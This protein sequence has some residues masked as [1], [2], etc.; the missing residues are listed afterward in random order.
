MLESKLQKD[1]LALL[2]E[3]DYYAVKII[4]CNRAGWMDIIACSPIG[5][6]VGI[7]LKRKGN[8]PSDLQKVHIQEVKA[9]GGIAFVAWSL[10][11][12]REGLAKG[13]RDD[14]TESNNPI[15]GL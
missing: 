10:D 4:S 15:I 7:E 9:R 11:D 5:L 14:G 13:Y 8:T 12:I 3:L 6:F 1:A 2:E